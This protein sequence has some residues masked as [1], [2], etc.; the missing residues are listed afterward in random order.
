[1]Q[2]ADTLV[3]YHSS[4]N[5]A[6]LLQGRRGLSRVLAIDSNYARAHA[7]LSKTYVSLWVQ[8]WD[9]DC[10]WSAAL[11]RAY[12][13]AR[14]AVRLAPNLPS[15]HAA[16]AWALIWTR[17]HE[18]A[19]AEF[20][21]AIVL[22]PNLND[23]FF[24]HTLLVAGEPA[25]AIQTL[26]AHMRL[27]PFYLPFAPWW[28]GIAYYMLGRYA[29]AVP[30]MQ[31]AVARAPDLGLCHHWLAATYAQL[32]RLYE[33]RAE[34]AEGLR[35]QPWFTIS[36]MPFTRACKRPEDAEHLKDGLLKAGYLE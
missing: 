24:A 14:E 33:A 18:A 4:L 25:R 1:L 30:P 29:D 35:I 26:E 15:A 11:D 6:D 7:A 21:R 9:D 2:A 22:N 34:A 8:R 23:F 13:S 16:L 36:Q 10:T 3:S 19:I 32:G 27:D 17:Q 28:L 31:A 5:K 20:E 12:Q